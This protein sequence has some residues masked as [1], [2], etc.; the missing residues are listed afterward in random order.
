MQSS[1]IARNAVSGEVTK[2]KH[3]ARD[4]DNEDSVEG[5]AEQKAITGFPATVAAAR[6]QQAP[7]LGR[8]ARFAGAEWA[9]SLFIFF[10]DI[11]CW[12]C[13]YAGLAFMRH[14]AVYSS[15]LEVALIDG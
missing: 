11:V 12:F 13:L 6:E 14:Q 10:L 7:A 1:A 5:S 4:Q 15:G 2:S 3:E 8:L 9:P